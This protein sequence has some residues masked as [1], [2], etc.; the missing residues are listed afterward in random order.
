MAKSKYQQMLLPMFDEKECAFK[1]EIPYLKTQLEEGRKIENGMRKQYKELEGACQK[2]KFEAKYTRE[3]LERIISN[4]QAT[5]RK[6]KNVG[7]A[8][9][10]MKKENNQKNQ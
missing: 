8:N 6:S 9:S 10:S 5:R 2:L 4:A 3:G 1:E 7:E